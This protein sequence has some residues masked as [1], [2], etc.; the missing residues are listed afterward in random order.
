MDSNRFSCPLYERRANG[1]KLTPVAV[2][3]EYHYGAGSVGCTTGRWYVGTGG[4]VTPGQP[5]P[6]G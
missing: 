3:R 1:H 4:S 6:Q 5:H 2:C